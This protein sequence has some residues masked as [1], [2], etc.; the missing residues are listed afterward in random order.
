M[1]GPRIRVVLPLLLSAAGFALAMVALFAGSTPGQ[2]ENLN[3]V[4]VS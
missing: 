1:L 4:S 2:M 3:I